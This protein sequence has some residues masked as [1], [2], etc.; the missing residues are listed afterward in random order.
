MMYV[1][2]YTLFVVNQNYITFVQKNTQEG[3]QLAE[4]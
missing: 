3:S 2:A 1:N 4:W